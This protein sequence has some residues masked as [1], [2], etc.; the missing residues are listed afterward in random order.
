[1]RLAPYTALAKA[2]FKANLGRLEFPLKLTFCLTFWCN[3][4]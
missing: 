1:V 4:R 2:A 3:S